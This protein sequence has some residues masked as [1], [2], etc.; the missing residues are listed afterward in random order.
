M[1]PDE[2]TPSGNGAIRQKCVQ[3]DRALARW[4]ERICVALLGLM[5]LTTTA[6]ITTRFVVFHPLNFA[7]P[8]AKYL[9]MWCA[10]LGVGLALRKGDHIA[11]DLLRNRLRGTPLTVLENVLGGLILVF[12][13]TVAFYGFGYAASGLD[14]RDPFVFG[15]SMAVPYASVPVGATTAALQLALSRMARQRHLTTEKPVSNISGI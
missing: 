11:V 1:N 13:G 5:V 6:S 2:S 4:V 14:S 15:V 3:W 12:L 9:M 8:L 7:D 10:F